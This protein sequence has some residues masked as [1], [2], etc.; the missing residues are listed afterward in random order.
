MKILF[1]H[2]TALELLRTQSLSGQKIKY[3]CG[4]NVPNTSL[5]KE[6]L[7]KVFL[8]IK[9]AY[10]VRLNL[11]IHYVI[12]D[13]EKLCHSHIVHAHYFTNKDCKGLF[14]ELLPGIGCS[15]PF[16]TALQMSNQL[17]NLELAYLLSEF[18]GLYSL[19]PHKDEKTLFERKPFL[20]KSEMLQQLENARGMKGTRRVTKATGISCENAASPME[21]KLY[22][23]ATLPFAQGGFG[24]P[25]VSLNPEVLTKTIGSNP[26]N[27]IRKPDLLFPHIG[28]RDSEPRDKKCFSAAIEYQG[29]H[30]STKDQQLK[31]ALRANEL[32]GTDIK[33]YIIWKS[34]YDD[35]V[36]M[37]GIFQEIRNTVGLPKR[38]CSKT[39]K[40][41]EYDAQITLYNA[42]EQIDGYFTDSDK[43]AFEN[44]FRETF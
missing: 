42:L 12:S 44:A 22:L 27:R 25:T 16:L 41:K 17:S 11:P 15:S 39:R 4:D 31:D 9:Q 37:R 7:R 33:E 32:T 30:H 35:A 43:N 6:E 38:I 10:G 29:E 21:I 24:F 3:I 28:N 2:T 18:M 8:M 14:I 19:P 40:Q 5:N 1:S 20:N 23:R 36:Y 34:T 13:R 26:V